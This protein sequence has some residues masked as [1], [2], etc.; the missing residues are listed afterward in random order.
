MRHERGPLIAQVQVVKAPLVQLANE[1]DVTERSTTCRRRQIPIAKFR[2]KT[3][4]VSS[5]K[6]GQ[7]PVPNSPLLNWPLF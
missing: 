2:P 5:K 1:L 4:P 7:R 3:D 6:V